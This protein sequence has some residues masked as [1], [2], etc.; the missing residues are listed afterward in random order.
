MVIA[1]YKT[2]SVLLILSHIHMMCVVMVCVMI[3]TCMDVK[4][5]SA[6][7]LIVITK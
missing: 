4:T 1:V 2:F 3:V 6:V 5:F 7:L